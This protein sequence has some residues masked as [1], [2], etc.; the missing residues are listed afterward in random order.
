M[1]PCDEVVD[2][3]AN[4]G[5]VEHPHVDVDHTDGIANLCFQNERILVRLDVCLTSCEIKLLVSPLLK[6]DRS[7]SREK[8]NHTW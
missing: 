8:G 5:V 1:S 6:L 2:S 3:P 4:D 7:S